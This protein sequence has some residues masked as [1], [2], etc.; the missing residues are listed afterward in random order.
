M[1]MRE[2]AHVNTKTVILLHW[3]AGAGARLD[4][5]RIIAAALTA[6]CIGGST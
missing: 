1:A 6:R 2:V 5:L 3:N 4:K